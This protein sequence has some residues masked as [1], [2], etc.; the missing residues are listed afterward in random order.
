MSTNPWNVPLWSIINLRFD[1]NAAETGPAYEK[2]SSLLA[3]T[4]RLNGSLVPPA[5]AALTTT[6]A[7]PVVVGVPLMGPVAGFK[8]RTDGGTFGEKRP[9]EDDED[10]EGRPHACRESAILFTNLSADRSKDCRQDPRRFRP[11]TGETRS[12]RNPPKPRKASPAEWCF[13]HDS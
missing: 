2:T 12:P 3:K 10:R 1:G 9:R 11:K 8:V 5:F 6:R 13:V 7:E 4:E